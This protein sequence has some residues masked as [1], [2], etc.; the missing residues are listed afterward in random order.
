M[1]VVLLS[2]C[3]CAEQFTDAIYWAGTIAVG[4]RHVSAACGVLNTGGNLAGGVVALAVPLTVHRLGWPVALGGGSAFAL[5]AAAL[6]LVT[7][8]DRGMAEPVRR[9]PGG[10]A[11]L[12]AVRN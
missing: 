12:A 9:R 3:L 11:C 7:A 8:V 1:A 6:W 10:G 2:L 4:G 5:A